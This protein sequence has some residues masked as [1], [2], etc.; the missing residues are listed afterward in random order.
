MKVGNVY[1]VTI[2]N[3][4]DFSGNETKMFDSYQTAIGYARYF[5]S[6]HKGF[7]LV[8]LTNRDE[9][10]KALVA[11][12]IDTNHIVVTT[13][14]VHNSFKKKY[15]VHASC[16]ENEGITLNVEAESVKEALT[17]ATEIAML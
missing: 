16:G 4:C 6:Q 2:F 14:E 1:M 12:M 11:T 7:E 3:V 10:L 9:D 5:Q 15:L 13:F 8:D 17:L